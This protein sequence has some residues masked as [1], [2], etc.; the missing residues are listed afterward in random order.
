M[1][2]AYPVALIL[3]I[4]LALSLTTFILWHRAGTNSV[5][6][7]EPHYLVMASGIAKYGSF[8]QTRPYQDERETKAIFKSGLPDTHAIQGPHGFYNVHNIGLPLLLAIPFLVGG[9]A[10]AKVF[11]ILASAVV[12]ILVWKVSG[13]FS[14][15]SKAKFLSTLAVCIAVPLIPASNQ[16]YPDILA[17]L[18]SLSGLYW[19]LTADRKRPRWMELG[20]ACAIVFLPWLQIKF[21][22]TC[23]LLVLAIAARSF[24]ASR[25]TGRVV[26]I[27]AAAFIS[28]VT[29]AAYNH[30][31]FGKFSGPY[32]SGAL[33]LSKTSIMVLLGLHIDQ[34]HGFLLQNPVNLLGLVAIGCIYRVNKPF[35]LLWGLVFL[36]LIVPNALHPAWYGGWSFSGRFGWSAAIVFTLPV[37]HG[38]LQLAK[39]NRHIFHAIV[40]LAVLMQAY[41]YWQYTAT[42]ISLY[43]KAATT[44]VDGYSI[45]YFPIQAWLPM[46]YN[47]GWAFG[48][49]PNYAWLLVTVSLVLAGFLAG[50][51]QRAFISVVLAA[52]IAGIVGS[53]FLPSAWP[54]ER[55]YQAKDLP[56]QVGRIDGASRVVE[57]G[58]HGA[59]YAS[60]GP[61]VPLNK[62]RY[63]LLVKYSSTAPADQVVGKF[64]VL[65]GTAGALYSERAL[66]GTGGELRVVEVPF[67]VTLWMR[68]AHEFR[69][70]WHGQHE[71]RLHEIGLQGH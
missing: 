66:Y 18:I 44:G 14:D 37:I 35:A 24:F 8:E 58:M 16:I 27:F 10:G 20:W 15:K 17:G 13:L 19:F 62:G 57:P 49:N 33:E 32:L 47:S 71:F 30:Y 50:A 39:A 52:G 2:R 55:I 3:F 12:V 7:D 11:M 6:G 68:H 61:Y 65:D 63:T 38:L 40:S 70:F 23:V 59:G 21:A 67:E 53:A 1:K 26:L 42:N 46:L 56:S 60:F 4:Y 48:Y 54:T 25:D 9:S 5:T 28:C 41:F 22:A 36:S 43:N 45:F 29:L 31:A 64:D 34:N 69:N 51:R